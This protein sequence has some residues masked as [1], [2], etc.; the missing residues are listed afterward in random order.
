MRLRGWA[1]RPA[2]TRRPM[3]GNENP[4]PVS[5]RDEDPPHR[6]PG[7]DIVG[8][9]TVGTEDTAMGAGQESDISHGDAGMGAGSGA[10]VPEDRDLGAGGHT[11]P[12]GADEIDPGSAS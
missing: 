9:E 3:S 10:D 1:G 2:G 6:E 12:G 11:G 8:G 7:G 4:N 5:D